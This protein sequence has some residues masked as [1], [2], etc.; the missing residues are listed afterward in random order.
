MTI[1][2]LLLALTGILGGI[3]LS[4]IAPEELKAGWKYF[5]I[6]QGALFIILTGFTGYSLWSMHN[7]LWLGIFAAVSILIFLLNLK[8]NYKWIDIINYTLFII[9]YFLLSS[10]HQILIAAALFIY[11]LP[12]GT[13][14][15]NIR[16][17]K[18]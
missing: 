4:F 18:E 7:I 3:A 5:K 8:S 13:L 10:S 9:P 12:T 14:L 2:P 16:Y 17:E 11:G 6:I 1:F 15:R